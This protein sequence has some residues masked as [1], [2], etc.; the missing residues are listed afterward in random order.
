VFQ[1]KQSLPRHYADAG[2]VSLY[3]GYLDAR[4]FTR[5]AP[6]YMVTGKFMRIWEFHSSLTTL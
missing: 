5:G 3:E 4:A 6:C 2:C 1:E